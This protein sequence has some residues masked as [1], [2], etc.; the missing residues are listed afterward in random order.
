[1]ATRSAVPSRAGKYITFQI[2]RRYFALE[3]ARVRSVIPV[4]DIL[5]C[6]H[7]SLGMRGVLAVHGRRVPVI[8]IRQRLGLD[9]CSNHPAASVLLIETGECGIPALGIIVDKLTDVIEFRE[10]DFRGNIIQQRAHGRP[11]GRPKTLLQLESLF[12]AEDLASLKS[13][14]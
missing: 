11:Y 3:A 13:T 12:T 10:R 1:M 14:F 9:D 2:A 7:S 4:R 5:A 6:D 8:D